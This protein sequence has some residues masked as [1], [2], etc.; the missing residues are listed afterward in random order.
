MRAVA[1]IINKSVQ[2]VGEMTNLELLKFRGVLDS[3]ISTKMNQ[4]ALLVDM[5]NQSVLEM[6]DEAKGKGL[7]RYDCKKYINQVKKASDGMIV[8]ND[9]KYDDREMQEGFGE[10]SDYLYQIF[11]IASR[12]ASTEKLESLLNEA[13]RLKGIPLNYEAKT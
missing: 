6:A 8:R 9:K 5:C 7:L 4:Q 12:M 11:D 13:K 2:E 10:L 1:Q 3:G